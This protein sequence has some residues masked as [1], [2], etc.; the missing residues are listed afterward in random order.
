MT[1]I[2]LVATDNTNHGSAFYMLTGTNDFEYILDTMIA[3]NTEICE[4]ISNEPDIP[5]EPVYFNDSKK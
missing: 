3:N 5:C 2:V 1:Q 4:K